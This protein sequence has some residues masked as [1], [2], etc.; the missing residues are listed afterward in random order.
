MCD[1]GVGRG[2]SGPGLLLGPRDTPVHAVH[3]HRN[4]HSTPPSKH[5]HTARATYAWT[6]RSELQ[7]SSREGTQC[8]CSSARACASPQTG[9][10]THAGAQ[11]ANVSATPHAPGALL[12]AKDTEVNYAATETR[13]HRQT[14]RERHL[15]QNYVSSVGRAEKAA[16]SVIRGIPRSFRERRYLTWKRKV[17]R[18]TPDAEGGTGYNRG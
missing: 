16:Q 8:A 4:T 3:P 18:N 13:K 11:G 14:D 17:S 10:F 15:K 2:C 6:R 9:T 1:S 5:V 12:G 7:C